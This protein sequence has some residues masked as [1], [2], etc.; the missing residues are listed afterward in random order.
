MYKQKFWYIPLQATS[1]IELIRA[2][3]RLP[4]YRSPITAKM[5]VHQSF[6]L[7]IFNDY[8]IKVF[9]LKT[10][11]DLWD[12]YEQAPNFTTKIYKLAWQ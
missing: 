2:S 5:M 12:E 7:I 4:A 9:L 10:Y 3:S 1:S 8:L 11:N 6:G